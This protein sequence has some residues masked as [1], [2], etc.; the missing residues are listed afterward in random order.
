LYTVFFTCIY[1]ID[2]FLFNLDQSN[3]CRDIQKIEPL[4]RKCLPIP[5]KIYKITKNRLRTPDEVE[6]YFPGFIAFID[7]TEQQIPR[8]IDKRK[9]K[10][11]YSGKK[12]RHT[13]KTQMMVNNL[14][15]FVHKTTKKKGH[16]HEYN[17][18]KKNHPV[19]SKQVVNVVDL[20]YLGIEKDFPQ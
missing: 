19:T 1:S 10:S 14:G 9:R 2:D 7:S 17:I 4:I 11:Y 6:Q 20:G 8:P 15:L 3:I 5:Q 16:V 13:V 18:Y 12:K